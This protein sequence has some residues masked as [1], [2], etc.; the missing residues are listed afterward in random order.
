MT[1]LRSQRYTPRCCKK[2][3]KKTGRFSM[4]CGVIMVNGAPG[5]FVNETRKEFWKCTVCGREITVDLAPDAK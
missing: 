1:M 3:C 5:S 4:T 2:R